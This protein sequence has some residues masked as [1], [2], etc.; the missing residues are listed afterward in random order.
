MRFITLSLLLSFALGGCVLLDP[1]NYDSENGVPEGTIEERHAWG[2]KHLGVTYRQAVDWIKKAEI[3]EETVGNVTAVAP[4]GKP[5]YVESFFT[6][7]LVGEHTIEIIGDQGKAVFS[8]SGITPCSSID[9]GDICFSDGI[10]ST[11]YSRILVHQ[12]G[13]TIVEFNRLINQNKIANLT[14]KI[15]KYNLQQDNPNYNIHEL[16]IESYQLYSANQDFVNAISDIETVIALLSE[17]LNNEMEE[18]SQE[19]SQLLT[20]KIEKYRYWLAYSYYYAKQ[21]SKSAKVL[22]SIFDNSSSIKHNKFLNQED[23]WLWT[24]RMRANQSKIANEELKKS[25]KIAIQQQDFCWIPFAQFLIG[26]LTEDFFIQKNKSSVSND[27]EYIDSQKIPLTYYYLGQKE[28]I[29]GNVLKGKS[30]LQKSLLNKSLLK[31]SIEYVFAV[32][33][34]NEV[35]AEI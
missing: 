6:D 15:N 5:N 1:L 20:R 10:L 25:L 35:L 9:E 28:L 4:L 14:D 3:V 29:Q 18:Q 33:E 11:K 21:F 22:K 26:E 8:A 19:E 2:Q 30:L 23:L 32:H 7:G 13:M 17:S 27:C 31:T 12:K 24:T 34:L 16:F